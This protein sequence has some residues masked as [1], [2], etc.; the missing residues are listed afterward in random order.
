MD[1]YT[2]NLSTFQS[3]KEF[4]MRLRF[5]RSICLV[6]IS[7]FL[8]T[9]PLFFH[10]A[11][12]GEADANRKTL[13]TPMGMDFVYISPGSFIMGSM[14]DV[15]GRDDDET[16]HKVTLTRGFYIQTTEVT[17]GQWKKIMQKNPAYFWRCG[18]DCPIE[19]VSWK[20]VQDFIRKLNE[21]EGKDT[22]RLPTEAE[23]EYVCRTGIPKPPPP[24]GSKDSVYVNKEDL[25]LDEISWFCKNSDIKTH[26]VAGKKPNLLGIYDMIGNVGEMC[27]DWYNLYPSEDVTDP[28]PEF[29]TLR[30]VRG[31][32]WSGCGRVCRIENRDRISPNRKKKSVGFR[33]V[34]N[35]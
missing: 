33:L 14:S 3:L 2:L 26:P 24:D 8:L 28:L 1:F 13:T 5:M 17:Q 22:Y 20:D 16:Q 15:P 4:Y 27:Q 19:N 23:W 9:T 11:R 18:K 35:P 25:H 32:A 34:R 29:G 31:C 10:S 7:A 6:S 12:A 21:R 30:I